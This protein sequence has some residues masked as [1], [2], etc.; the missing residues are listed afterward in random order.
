MSL[1]RVGQQV[2][3]ASNSGITFEIIRINL[4]R[5]FEIQVKGLDLNRLKFDHVSAEML[6]LVELAEVVSC[7]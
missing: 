2:Y 4:D 7:D 1:F 5:T 3:L 6:Q